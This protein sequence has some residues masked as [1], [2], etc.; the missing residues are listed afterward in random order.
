[1]KK[2]SALV[3]VLIIVGT[4]SAC[5]IFKP[6]GNTSAVSS[7]IEAAPEPTEKPTEKPEEKPTAAP[8][9]T[10]SP[11]AAV[12]TEADMLKA[13]GEYSAFEKFWYEGG[14]SSAMIQGAEPVDVDGVPYCQ[15][16]TES[17]KTFEELKNAALLIMSQ[18]VFDS[19][20][21]KV[22]Y[23]DKDGALLGPV[24]YG[25]GDDSAAAG[26]EGDY[27]KISDTEYEMKIG[28]Y[29]FMTAF[30]PEADPEKKLLVSETTCRYSLVKDRWIF[31][32][33]DT[34]VTQSVAG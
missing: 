15:Y 27:V 18:D 24:N 29:V 17:I 21:A 20:Q 22:N 1:M 6:Q 19:L 7:D 8:T 33:V 3:L 5:S 23:I 28:N 12:P 31:T 10:A 11:K 4:F 2:L 32:K 16:S 26:N 14:N 34:K 9:P 13:Y 25:Q 30:D